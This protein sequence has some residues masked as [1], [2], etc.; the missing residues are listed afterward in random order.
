M[1]C[2][3]FF[4]WLMFVFFFWVLLV[5]VWGCFIVPFVPLYSKKCRVFGNNNK[6]HNVCQNIPQ[7]ETVKQPK[8][9]PI[10]QKNFPCPLIVPPQSTSPR[11]WTEWRLVIHLGSIQRKFLGKFS[12]IF[13]EFF[14]RNV[15]KH[16]FWSEVYA[17]GSRRPPRRGQGT[18]TALIIL[19]FSSLSTLSLLFNHPG[20]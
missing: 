17:F 9:R 7:R 6:N 15:M 10:S 11:F 4:P 14:S 8:E 3:S 2:K 16:K 5:F 1:W 18:S 13:L 19:R 12:W 20:A